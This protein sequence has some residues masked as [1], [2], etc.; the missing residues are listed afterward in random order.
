[1]GGCWGSTYVSR[2]PARAGPMH[3]VMS[4]A[5]TSLDH[6]FSARR[7]DFERAYDIADAINARAAYLVLLAKRPVTRGQH[8]FGIAISGALETTLAERF[9]RDFLD[10]KVYETAIAEVSN[11]LSALSSGVVSVGP[12]HAPN[13]HRA[14]L[15]IA[16]HVI[17]EALDVYNAPSCIRDLS[18]SELGEDLRAGWKKV[19]RR[20]AKI[21]WDSDHLSAL[22]E[23]ELCKALDRTKRRVVLTSDE[24]WSVPK[25][26]SEWARLFNM[27]W[28]TLKPLFESQTIRNKQLSPKLYRVHRTELPDTA[29]QNGGTP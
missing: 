8:L 29:P 12:Y 4:M 28:D 1:M 26:P 23:I 16:Q 7:A 6:P 19:R 25:M 9:A 5:R 20:I 11:V 17:Y 13:A 10:E 24:H 2:I 14:A 21:S 3:M 27:S 18:L 22:L 15:Q